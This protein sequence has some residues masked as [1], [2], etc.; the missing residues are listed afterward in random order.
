MAFN[1]LG[2]IHI[3]RQIM[4][5]RTFSFD[6]EYIKMFLSWY[7][8]NLI[9][10]AKNMIPGISREHILDALIPV[11]PSKE[12]QMIIEKMNQIFTLFH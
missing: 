2:N 4:A 5:I 8:P 11:P 10:Q 6:I 7:M 9:Q 1:T 3:A 12:Q